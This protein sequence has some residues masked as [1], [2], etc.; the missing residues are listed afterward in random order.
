MNDEC[1]AYVYVCP[2]CHREGPAN[3]ATFDVLNGWRCSHCRRPAIVF[4]LRQ[5]G[6]GY[7]RI[8]IPT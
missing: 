1:N 6:D 3:L 2:Y 5:K 8:E 7:E 4:Q